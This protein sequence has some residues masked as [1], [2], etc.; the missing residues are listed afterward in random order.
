MEYLNIIVQDAYVLAALIAKAACNPLDTSRIPEIYNSIR[1]PLGNQVLIDSR[2]QGLRSQL[3]A[4]GF[5]DV[6][7][8][9]FVPM[10][11][12]LDLF[13]DMLR[14]WDWMWTTS[15]EDDRKRAVDMM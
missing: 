9:D 14:A 8:G 3:I 4:P 13:E 7:E 15:A 6:K 10:S 12:L 11:K 5:E 2:T 1:R